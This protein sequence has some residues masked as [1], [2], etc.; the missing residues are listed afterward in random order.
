MNKHQYECVWG[1]LLKVQ[2]ESGL[3]GLGLVALLQSS[4]LS[5][6]ALINS[7]M[8]RRRVSAQRNVSKSEERV[9]ILRTGSNIQ[10]KRN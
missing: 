2:V 7:C 3:Q 1:V 4:N 8:R 9:I 6:I 5:A 10:K